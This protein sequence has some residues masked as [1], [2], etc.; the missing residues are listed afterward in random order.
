MPET[1]IT[2]H[3]YRVKIHPLLTFG[4]EILLSTTEQ[5]GF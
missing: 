5:S 2:L 3:Y 4:F 1:V